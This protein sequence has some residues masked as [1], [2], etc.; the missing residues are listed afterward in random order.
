MPLPAVGATAP[1]FAL[2]NQDGQPVR[3]ADL[4]GSRVL[5]WFYS[6]AFGSN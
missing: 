5:L 4:G 1:E 3:L 6:R 2:S